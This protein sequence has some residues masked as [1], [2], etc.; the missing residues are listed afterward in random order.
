M[1]RAA[2]R[3]RPW[4][5]HGEVGPGGEDE[6]LARDSGRYDLTGVRAGR[7]PLDGGLQGGESRGAERRGPG[8]VTAVVEGDQSHQAGAPG[9]VDVPHQGIGDDLRRKG[10]L[11]H[12]ACSLP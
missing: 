9:Q 7:D 12:A 8:V 6:R 2:S 3:V 4:R 11:A 1:P 5:H 10:L